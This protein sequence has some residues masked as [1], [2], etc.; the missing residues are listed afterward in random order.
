MHFYLQ[1]SQQK[2]TLF[3]KHAYC[4]KKNLCII[5]KITHA[6]GKYSQGL[7]G[8]AISEES[9]KSTKT[10]YYLTYFVM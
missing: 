5:C 9:F 7:M 2:P 6:T 3:N 8:P 4:K 10:I 1:P